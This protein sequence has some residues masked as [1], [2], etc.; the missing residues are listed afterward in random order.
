MFL[1][2]KVAGMITVDNAAEWS[3][4][5]TRVGQQSEAYFNLFIQNNRKGGTAK[6]GGTAKVRSRTHVRRM[7]PRSGFLVPSFRLFYPCSS[8]GG[9][10]TP[11]LCTL[12]P[13]FV[14]SSRFFVV[15]EHLPKPPFWKPP[16]LRTPENSPWPTPLSWD[17]RDE[18]LEIAG[19]LV[20]LHLE[21]LAYSWVSLLAVRWG[22]Y[23]TQLPTIPSHSLHNIQ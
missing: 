2:R 23:E 17:R 10:G 21:L 5:A 6:G 22:A 3:V 15:R 4:L 11:V 13:D 20:Y 8:F 12:V 9:P 7:C 14:A 16:F 18:W 1:P 19:S